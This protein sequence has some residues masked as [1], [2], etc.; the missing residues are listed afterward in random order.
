MGKKPECAKPVADR[1]HHRTAP[2]ELIAP[3]ERHGRVAIGE[4]AAVN[5]HDYRQ[6]SGTSGRPDV[7]VETILADTWRRLPGM[8]VPA[9]I[10]AGANEVAER[11]PSHG[12][13]GCGS[14]HRRSPTGGCAK[15]TPLYAT[16]ALSSVP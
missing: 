15:G 12:L 6:I 16:T 1:D 4:A 5:P 8:E 14:R 13:S 11:V 7:E 3:V 10:Q 9:C 2:R